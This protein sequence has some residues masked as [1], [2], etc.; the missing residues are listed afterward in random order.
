MGGSGF[1]HAGAAATATCAG[2]LRSGLR[3]SLDKFRPTLP[4]LIGEQRVGGGEGEGGDAG[5]QGGGEEE[6]GGFHDG[7][8]FWM[9]CRT[10]CAAVFPAYT[11]GPEITQKIIL[12]PD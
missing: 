11:G 8:G 5:E 9:E 10:K 7:F 1:L 12:L 3:P 2:N 4:R 6:F